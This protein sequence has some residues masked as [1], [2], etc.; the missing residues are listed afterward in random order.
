LTHLPSPRA[1]IESW[2]HA[3]RSGAILAIHETEALH[4]THQHFLA[5]TIWWPRCRNTTARS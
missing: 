2:A 5:I 1:A 3:A 4:S